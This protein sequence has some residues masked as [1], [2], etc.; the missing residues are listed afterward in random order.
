MVNWWMLGPLGFT[1]IRPALGSA[2][3]E[4]LFQHGVC[5][6]VAFPFTLKSI[7]RE[8]KNYENS[9]ISPCKDTIFKKSSKRNKNPSRSYLYN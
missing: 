6:T 2:S 3:C 4:P 7:S 8:E 9:N 5:H 1:R